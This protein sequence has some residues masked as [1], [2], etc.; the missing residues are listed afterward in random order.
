MWLTED[1]LCSLVTGGMLTTA[2][3][4]NFNATFKT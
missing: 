3:F 1:E 2:V 4:V